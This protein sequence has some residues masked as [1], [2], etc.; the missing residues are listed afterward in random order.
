MKSGLSQIVGR[1]IAGVVVATK[2]RSP[3]EQVFLTFTD[4]T[5]FEFWGDNFSCG[6][7]VDAGGPDVAIEYVLR[8]HGKVTARYG[9]AKA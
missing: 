6:G 5:H 9:D 1:Q 7:G 4:G 8:N 3:R 2:D